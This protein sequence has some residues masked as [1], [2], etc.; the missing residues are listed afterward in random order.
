MKPRNRLILVALMAI[1][2][3][4]GLSIRNYDEFFPPSVAAYAPDMLWT[5]LVFWLIGFIFPRLD[6]WAVTAISIAISLTVEL[7][8]FYHAPWIDSIRATTIGALVLGHGF[9]WSD[10][11]CYVAGGLLGCVIEIAILRFAKSQKRAESKST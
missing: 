3:V 11:A 4:L 8:Q 6:T 1:T 7:S 2:A 9:L 10:L 5:L